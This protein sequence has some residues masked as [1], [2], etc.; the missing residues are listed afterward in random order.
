MNKP[1]NQ[2]LKQK[3][4]RSTAL[5]ASVLFTRQCEQRLTD[6]VPESWQVYDT[7]LSGQAQKNLLYVLTLRSAAAE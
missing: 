3:V 6:F 1:N 4:T 2:I 5:M 7:P